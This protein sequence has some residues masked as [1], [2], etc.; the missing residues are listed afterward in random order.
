MMEA[1]LRGRRI[2]ECA[3]EQ[4]LE[5]AINGDS[6]PGV[7]SMLA[8]LDDGTD[9]GREGARRLAAFHAGVRP[10]FHSFSHGGKAQLVDRMHEH[11]IQGRPPSEQV[12]SALKIA[13]GYGAL[14]VASL[15]SIYE[16]EQLMAVA[17]RLMRA[18]G[19]NADGVSTDAAT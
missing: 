16:D 7:G 15:W 4:Q 1:Y 18:A 17:T 11:G 12:E 14:V 19:V 9:L 13:V 2:R 10:T 5:K 3:D 8:A 6:F